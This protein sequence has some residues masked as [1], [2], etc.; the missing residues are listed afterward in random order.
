MGHELEVITD[1]EASERRGYCQTWL[2]GR[3]P[4]DVAIR[5]VFTVTDQILRAGRPTSAPAVS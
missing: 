2:Q 5:Q 3:G 4:P 1:E